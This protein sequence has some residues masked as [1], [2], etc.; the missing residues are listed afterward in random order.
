M[1][2]HPSLLG[3]DPDTLAHKLQR[4]QELLQEADV[5]RMVAQHPRLLTSDPDTLAHK[6]QGLQ[7]LLP[8]ADAAK[9]AG[10]QAALLGRDPDT[11]ARNLQR[12]QE[13]LPEAD[14]AKMVCSQPALLGRKP[15][16][17]ERNYRSLRAHASLVPRWLR[18][19]Q[20]YLS[21]KPGTLSVALMYS[22]ARHERLAHVAG[23][24]E[25]E[26]SQ[27]SLI[28]LLSMTEARFMG[29]YPGSGSRARDEP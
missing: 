15:E 14:V 8:E 10:K 6:L 4:L 9:M 2:Q 20:S 28:T 3:S 19:L 24:E 13:L 26:R 7:E 17:L 21:E 5:A 1:R 11:L 22:K 12:L 18:E 27:Y 29:R 23:L 25:E 16:S